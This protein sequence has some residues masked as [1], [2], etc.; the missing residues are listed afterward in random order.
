VKLVVAWLAVLVLAVATAS[1]CSIKH[2]SEQFE[3]DTQAD[4]DALGD[5]RECVDGLCV[6]LGGG[7]GT[8]KDAGTD[9]RPDAPLPP[10]AAT[11]PSQCTACD[12]QRKECLIDCAANPAGCNGQVVCPPGFA[13]NIKCST[14]NA[15]RNGVSCLDATA[16]NIECSGFGSCRNVACGPGRCR[17]SCSGTDSCRGIA[18]GQSC[19]CDVLCP[20]PARCE[21]V[22]CTALTCGTFSGGCTSMR[23]GC[24]TCP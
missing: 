17:T 6:V 4:C 14:P 18:C 22:V 10:D 2:P 19:A 1:S 5:G 12:L 20:D 9:P 24:N 7:S 13:C 3:C 8:K 23:T 21:N 11:C 15:C 16:C